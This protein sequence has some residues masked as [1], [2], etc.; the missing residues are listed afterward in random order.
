MSDSVGGR[1]AVSIRLEG[2]YRLDYP[3]TYPGGPSVYVA[4][5]ADMA[6][7]QFAS[8]LLIGR[9]DRRRVRVTQELERPGVPGAVA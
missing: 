5:I 9:V 1:F 3:E 6:V 7:E 2:S 8:Q 4:D